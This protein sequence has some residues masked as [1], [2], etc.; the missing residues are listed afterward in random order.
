MSY[1]SVQTCLPRCHGAGSVLSGPVAAQGQYC[2]S[3]SR[4]FFVTR[5]RGTEELSPADGADGA[6][7]PGE[8]SA[9]TAAARGEKGIAVAPKVWQQ[10]TAAA[11]EAG[12]TVPT[13]L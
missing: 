7:Y 4:L 5:T 3:W 2:G 11:A 6:F 12:I 13:V 1:A 8:R 10:L 9:A